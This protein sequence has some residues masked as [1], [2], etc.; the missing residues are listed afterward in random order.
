M[1][2]INVSTK[3]GVFNFVL[4]EGALYPPFPT[5]EMMFDMQFATELLLQWSTQV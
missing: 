5:F 2:D 1:F 3:S 4:G